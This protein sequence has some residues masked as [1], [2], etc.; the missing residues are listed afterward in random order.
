MAAAF[1]LSDAAEA[2]ETTTTA[3]SM[4]LLGSLKYLLQVAP[5]SRSAATDC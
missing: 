5:I 3:R 4:T 1:I 2:I